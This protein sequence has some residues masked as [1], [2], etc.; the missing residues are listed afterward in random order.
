MTIHELREKLE[1]IGYRSVDGG[2]YSL[3]VQPWSIDMCFTGND[4]GM[5]FDAARLYRLS[6]HDAW[7]N[8]V[9]IGRAE[10]YALMYM[11]DVI[12]RLRTAAAAEGMALS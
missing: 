11:Q 6:L 12:E 2:M 3:I 8:I 7:T 1:A 10:P 5:P 4:A 9:N